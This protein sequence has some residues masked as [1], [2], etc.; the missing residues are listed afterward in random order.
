MGGRFLVMDFSE[1][2]SGE[3]GYAKPMSEEFINKEMEL[4]LEQARECDVIITTAAIPGRKA[5]ILLKQYH[6]DA[7]KSGSIIV[8]L[9]ALTGGNCEVTKPGE[10]Y[11][12]DSKVTVIGD[13]DF[14]SKMA[15]QASAMYAN[16]IYHL[17]HHCGGGKDFKLNQEDDIIQTITVA[18]EGLVTWPPKRIAGPPPQTKKD[19]PGAAQLQDGSKTKKSIFSK[20]ICGPVTFG[21]LTAL[22]AIAACLA[23]F[24]ALG[25]ETFVPQLMVFVLACWVGYMLIWNVAPALH[26]PLM[27]V[28]NAI[29]GIVVLGGILGVSMREFE[30]LGGEKRGLVSII[31]NAVAIGV[32]S[33]NVAGGFAVTQRMLSMFKKSD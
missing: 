31:L 6:V 11:L 9:A 4:F 3:G 17:L 10:T 32:A 28:S 33:M 24:A 8:D 18:H 20:R 15:A 23:V 25:P 21:T 14:P 30:N 2:G 16:N 22:G 12:Y 13:T 7:M 26:T 27:S 5:P 1:D 19:A 29:S